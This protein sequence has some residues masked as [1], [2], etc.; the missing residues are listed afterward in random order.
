MTQ[1]TPAEFARSPSA[2]FARLAFL[3]ASGRSA[4]GRLMRARTLIC[5]SGRCDRL[6]AVGPTDRRDDY[7]ERRPGVGDLS[8][9][10]RNRVDQTLSHNNFSYVPG[11]V[12]SAAFSAEDSGVTVTTWSCPILSV[13]AERLPVTHGALPGIFEARGRIKFMC[14]I[15]LRAA[16][17]RDL[18]QLTLPFLRY[19][20]AGMQQCPGDALAPV[21][22]GHNQR[23]DARKWAT[24]GQPRYSVKRYQAA[25]CYQDAIRIVQS[26][27]AILDLRALQRIA[28]FS[29]KRPDCR[30]V[31]SLCA[32]DLHE[33][34]VCQPH[35]RQ[36]VSAPP[37]VEAATAFCTSPEIPTDYS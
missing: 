1:L 35:S 7:E 2:R 15:T 34:Q 32:A 23:C 22:G 6:R 8:H 37:L 20:F 36:T 18:D 30:R 26:G 13:V 25:S 10:Q 14:R 17:A 9:F 12:T 29:K 24:L 16:C 3:P 31:G 21:V 33:R 27:E 5:V 28:E 4:F 19:T 11:V